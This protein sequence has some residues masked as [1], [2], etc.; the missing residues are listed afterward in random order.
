MNRA[1]AMVINEVHPAPDVELALEYRDEAHGYHAF[2]VIHST[3]RGPAVGG[4][5]RTRYP[6]RAAAL[7]DALALARNMSYKSAAADLPFGGGKSV[8]WDTGATTRTTLYRLHAEVIQELGGRYIGGEDL[9]TTPRDIDGMRSITRFVAG[10]TDPAPWTARGVLR[11]IQAAALH[12]W[13]SD[14]LLGCMV[15]LHGC[16]A[17]GT[18]L[19][20]ELHNAGASL[21]VADTDRER[22]RY[23]VRRFRA[24][25]VDPSELL[26][27]RA[28]VL[29][30]C[31]FGGLLDADTI[32]RL[33]VAI[34]AGAANNQLRRPDGAEALARRGILYVPD[35]LINVGGL[36]T[37]GVHLLGWPLGELSRRVDGI[38]EA[39]LQIL[40]EAAGRSLTPLAV[41]NRVVTERLCEPRPGA[42]R[43]VQ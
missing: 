41:A 2:V 8:I 17:V 32:P 31:A 27:L 21:L 12:R 24:F 36:M 18:C 5:R 1:S 20:Q 11:G 34:V 10:E 3:A 22:A 37:G 35:Y 15:A 40:A 29:A 13:K 25:A 43:L 19:A 26:R 4:I 23:V 16:G 7:E 6:N 33:Q 28:D 42:P 9:G 38:R 39:V 14:D 30:P